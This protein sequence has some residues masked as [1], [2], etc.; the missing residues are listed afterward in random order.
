MAVEVCMCVR[1]RPTSV[2]VAVSMT[3][4]APGRPPRNTKTL[5]Q[6]IASSGHDDHL[7]L[8]SVSSSLYVAGMHMNIGGSL[9]NMGKPEEAL[10]HMQNGLEIKLKLLGSEHPSIDCSSD[11]CVCVATSYRSLGSCYFDQGQLERALEYFQKDLEIFIKVSDQDSLG[12]STGVLG[13][14]HGGLNLARNYSC[15][16]VVY[17]G[18][19]Q[20]EQALEYHQKDLDITLRLVG[21]TIQM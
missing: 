6:K 9:A 17:F 3:R 2:Y 21:G 20:Y 1:G 5:A 19:G 4:G 16:G 10:V 13:Y 11:C 7:S 15:S 18:L 12:G 14:Y 8:A